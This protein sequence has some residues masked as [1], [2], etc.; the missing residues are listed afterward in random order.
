M[1]LDEFLD[2]QAPL[3]GAV[4]AAAD[5]FAQQNIA[6]PLPVAGPAQGDF[7]HWRPPMQH[8]AAADALKLQSADAALLAGASRR[9]NPHGASAAASQHPQAQPFG[10]SQSPVTAGFG[11]PHSRSKVLIVA[12][13]PIAFDASFGQRAKGCILIAGSQ[14]QPHTALVHRDHS[15]SHPVSAPAMLLGPADTQ[16]GW[17][18]LTHV[19]V[20]SLRRAMAAGACR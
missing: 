19:H 10:G 3:S 18:W 17:L 20:P 1:P 7:D 11:R 16:R 4:A 15:A 8:G 5:S 12:E 14:I 9:A 13:A 2:A 6:A